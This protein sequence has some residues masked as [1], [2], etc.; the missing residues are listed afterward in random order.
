MKNKKALKY[1]GASIVYS[2]LVIVA[3]ILLNVVVSALGD[4][5]Y[6]AFHPDIS[7]EQLFN[8]SDT[9]H[10]LF[11]MM[12]SELSDEQKDILYEKKVEIIFMNS[13]ATVS[14]TSNENYRRV[15][16]M[17]KQY[18]DEFSFIDLKFIEP[19]KNPELV[20]KFVIDSNKNGAASIE[21][22]DIYFSGPLGNYFSVPYTGFYLSDSGSSEK[23]TVYNIESKMTG[24]ILQLFSTNSIAYIVSGH[25]EDTELTEFR[26]LLRIAGFTVQD[27]DL[28]KD[29]LDNENGKLIIINSPKKD[30]GGMNDPCNE[31]KKL[32]DFVSYSK[33]PHHMMIFIDNESLV[34]GNLTELTDFMTDYG[35]IFN[36]NSV[37]EPTNNLDRDPKIIE[38]SYVAKEISTSNSNGMGY[39]FVKNILDYKTYISNAG[40]IKLQNPKSSSLKDT[41][42]VDSI[43]TTS[44]SATATDL[45][46]QHQTYDATYATLVGIYGHE[47]VVD[48]SGTYVSYVLAGSSSS[49]VSNEYL[50]KYGNRNIIYSALRTMSLNSVDP[51]AQNISYKVYLETGLSMKGGEQILWTVFISLVIP[52]VIFVVGIVVF[53][54]RKNS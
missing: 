19:D 16:E 38:A 26:E 25:G 22:T 13:E 20:Q 32:G 12:L 45:G 6:A 18:K 15:Y 1:S 24:S 42:F 54:R 7:P 11:D 27:V 3:I 50:A 33:I 35:F 49:F 2:A 29:E 51:V 47:M 40:T 14:T 30:F 8:I 48:D 17:A 34:D 5:F 9:T 43:I 44:G 21:T 4:T 52:F 36:A 37:S 39:S 31:I 28:S 46:G 10:K 23:Y 41:Y 53:I